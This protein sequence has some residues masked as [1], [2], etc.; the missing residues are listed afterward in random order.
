M[1]TNKSIKT[2][3]DATST[4]PSW[5]VL[6]LTVEP[7]VDRAKLE[8]ADEIVVVIDAEDA[9]ENVG[10]ILSSNVLGAGNECDAEGIR[11]TRGDPVTDPSP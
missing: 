7:E 4:E 6:T 10:R 1:S 2:R 3:S 11:S 8:I 5:D 9:C